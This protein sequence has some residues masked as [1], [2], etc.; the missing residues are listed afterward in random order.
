MATGTFASRPGGFAVKTAV[1]SLTRRAKVA[2]SQNLCDVITAGGLSARMISTG[3]TVSDAADADAGSFTNQTPVTTETYFAEIM[4]PYAVSVTGIAFLNGSDVTGNITGALADASGAIIAVTATTAGSGT[5]AY[6][7]IALTSGPFV[8]PPGT[9]FI[10]RQNSS[11]TGRLAAHTFG[12]FATGK[13]T[14][15]TNGTITAITPTTTFTT[16]IGPVASLY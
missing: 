12:N 8:I 7:R 3:N 10:C 6:Q 9:Y 5:D 1:Q 14:G 2:A 15:E 13:T 4:V 11:G 16:A